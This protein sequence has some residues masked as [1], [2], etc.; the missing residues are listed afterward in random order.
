MVYM[1]EELYNHI[2]GDYAKAISRM[3][4]DERIK[5][6]L[7]FFLMDESYQQLAQAMEAHNCEEAFRGAHTLKG[8]SQNMAF[9]VLG[10][11]VEQITEELRAKDFDKA[12]ETFPKVTESYQKVIEEIKRIME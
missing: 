10:N 8:V 11:I 12:L 2:G 9:A 6:Y 7:K 1:I 3:Q 5:K 4:N